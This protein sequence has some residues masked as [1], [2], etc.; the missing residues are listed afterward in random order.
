[1]TTPGDGNNEIEV[2]VH[3]VV[4]GNAEEIA[5]GLG[6]QAGAGW[7][8]GVESA[9]RPVLKGINT[10]EAEQQLQASLERMERR[11]RQAAQDMNVPLNPGSNGAVGL[12]GHDLEA[13]LHRY[14]RQMESYGGTVKPTFVGGFTEAL[15]RDT[16][17]LAQGYDELAE[18]NKR[19]KQIPWAFNEEG[20]KFLASAGRPT[21][22]SDRSGAF[23]ESAF[24]TP[25]R[26]G[27]SG[28][29]AERGDVDRILNDAN[30]RLL[31]GEA[32]ATILNDHVKQLAERPNSLFTQYGLGDPTT[33]Y[34]TAGGRT[35]SGQE[36]GGIVGESVRD[37]G[38]E[39]RGLS[40]ALV[41][42]KE[43]GVQAPEVIT[44]LEG[45]LHG[46]VEAGEQATRAVALQAQEE[47][48]LAGEANL[49]SRLGLAGPPNE[50]REGVQRRLD[51]AFNKPL[52]EGLPP[53][54]HGTL[55]AGEYQQEQRRNFDLLA[56][57]AEQERL[58]SIPPPYVPQPVPRFVRSAEEE[59]ALQARNEAESAARR[60]RNEENLARI[61]PAALESKQAREVF[62]E[63]QKNLGSG[64][65]GG[66]GGGPR[67]AVA[68]FPDD[69]PARRAI[70]AKLQQLT[71]LTDA[72]ILNGRLT[73]TDK[74]D[75]QR[76]GSF[77]DGN[78]AARGPNGEIFTASTN[79]GGSPLKQI[80]DTDAYAR[81]QSDLAATT[82]Q[83]AESLELETA[84]LERDG[85]ALKR[86]AQFSQDA[87]IAKLNFIASN[88]R[89]ADE[90]AKEIQDP[91]KLASALQRQARDTKAYEAE[92]R[93]PE[94]QRGFV[95]SFFHAATGGD[96]KDDGDNAHRRLSGDNGE[97][98][99]AIA[100]YQA[101][102]AVIFGLSQA[103]H[104]VLSE[105]EAVQLAM[106]E[107]GEAT[108][109][110]GD[111]ADKLASSLAQ[112]GSRAGLGVA[113]SIEAGTRGAFAF[114]DETRGPNGE[115]DSA[116][117]A[118][119]ATA[120][121]QTASIAA[122]ITQ[123][124]DAGVVQGQLIAT[125]RSFNLEAG[126]Q[127]RV[128]DAAANA[129]RHYGASTADILQGLPGVAGIAHQAG[130]SVEETANIISV[131][132]VRTAQTG[133]AVS[134][135]IGRV[136]ENINSKPSTKTLLDTFGVDTGGT[137]G[138]SLESLAHK[139]KD[140]TTAQQ[141]QIIA[142]LGGVRAAKDLIPVLQEGDNIL[143]A[144]E[145]SYK[146]GGYAQEL[147]YKQLNTIGG[148]LKLISGDLGIIGHDLASSGLFTVFGAALATIDP[149]LQGLDD[150][151]KI[152]GGLN[153]ATHG[154]LIPLLEVAAV[155][156]IISKEMT[157]NAALAAESAAAAT[158]EAGARTEEAVVT[159]GGPLGFFQRRAVGRGAALGAE[160]ARLTEAEIAASEAGIAGTAA[161]TAARAGAGAA[162]IPGL[163]GEVGGTA[164]LAETTAARGGLALMGSAL[165]GPVGIIVGL[166]AMT[167]AVGAITSKIREEHEAR[168]AADDANRELRTAGA[169][170]NN[171]RSAAAALSAAAVKQ[172]HANSGVTGFLVRSATDIAR[173][174]LLREQAKFAQE[175]ARQIEQEQRAATTAGAGEFFTH[176]G[177]VAKDFANGL[178][179]MTEAG[180]PAVRQLA[181]IT[182]ALNGLTPG[183]GKAA[184][185]G[186]SRGAAS[187]AGLVSNITS[188]VPKIEGFGGFAG[189]EVTPDIVKLG[190]EGTL[191]E[192]HVKV[193]DPITPQIR[194][195]IAQNL[196]ALYGLGD[197]AKRDHP[198]QFA[199]IQ[200]ELTQAVELSAGTNDPNRFKGLSQSEFNSAVLGDPSKHA[201]GLLAA[202]STQG[203]SGNALELDG[204]KL[205]PLAGQVNA[206]KA[207]VAQGTAA[208][209]VIPREVIDGLNQAKADLV[210]GQ[211]ASIEQIRKHELTGAS[212]AE[213]A[214][215]VNARRVTQEV[216]A[217]LD[218]NDTQ[219][220]INILDSADQ[221]TIDL[222]RHV[223]RAALAIAQKAHDLYL[224]QLAEF[225]AIPAAIR[226]HDPEL[227]GGGGG[228]PSDTSGYGK[229]KGDL[230]TFE[231]GAGRATA[232]D[233]P[234]V[235]PIA[236]GLAQINARADSRDAVQSA[237]TAV[238]AAQY[239]LDHA[240][241]VAAKSSAQKAL[242]DANH[243]YTA[244]VASNTQAIRTAGTDPSNAL[245]Q[246]QTAVANAQT[247]LN[248]TE[249]GTTAYYQ[250][251]ATLH[252]AQHSLGQAAHAH[253][254]AAAAGSARQGDPLSAA[255]VA[256]HAA[257][258]ALQA[259][260]HGSDAWYQ[261]LASFHAAQYAYGQAILARQHELRLN[262]IDTTNPVAVARE[263]LLTAQRTL[264]RDLHNGTG[265]IAADRN[266]VKDA[267][268][269]A[270]A[271]AFSQRLHDQ[272]Y[273]H[274]AGRESDQAYL[275]Y[276]NS[277]HDRLTR[278][279]HR[280]R[281]QTE[282]LQ[283]IDSA[284]KAA[285]VAA[286]GQFNLGDIK[287]PTP[288]EARR[289]IQASGQG[290]SYQSTN[291]TNVN[292]N[293]FSF[294][295]LSRQ[296]VEQVLRDVLGPA[297]TQRSAT[298]ARK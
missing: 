120:S 78:Y 152:V 222:V 179:A 175:Q 24:P 262:A 180:V 224:A 288:Y 106:V 195:K 215:Q 68:G 181:L 292:N 240:K 193:G 110:A 227:R 31:A 264:A 14:E 271:A 59:A 6:E 257:D 168:K 239:T 35:I 30:R 185:D 111:K 249:K 226:A 298:A 39:M 105:E 5:R 37:A 206:L 27:Y 136:L 158:V 194:A 154:W 82:R 272:Q 190:V 108:G 210:S 162:S 207:L 61:N 191:D 64:G 160:G 186:I 25:P 88:R 13:E 203:K 199:K 169:D 117:A 263:N 267:Q 96:K 225:N 163:A 141:D 255:T 151:L 213:Q 269:A 170:P 285:A 183:K 123:A 164:V 16:K 28:A 284:I 277:E 97:F 128:L 217:A 174:D 138:Q 232:T 286:Q 287:I 270:E 243:A 127:A 74:V 44:R 146:Q 252:S 122:F 62:E 12:F 116:K 40:D 43:V 95:G 45:A 11:V 208:G 49:H 10:Q 86:D 121:V 178:T 58:A 113:A 157:K 115:I 279:T 205:G 291:T 189:G 244:A 50:D 91:A 256:L 101:A 72:Q 8:Q 63:L 142:S 139:W 201:T 80:T 297:A 235:D 19:G 135:A 69:D 281:Q 276:L 137:A 153:N 17:L 218:Q 81:A 167:A 9:P 150:V 93:G 1:M 36:I 246:A 47:Q 57:Q 103:F 192:A 159:R 278:I 197:Q 60:Q 87:S 173:P 211:V 23:Q 3:P 247:A 55:T 166:I 223:L 188:A 132:A 119:V 219:A 18:V 34:P 4:E 26:G 216:R 237:R 149:F 109:L 295:G 107:F 20:R 273:A 118:S 145:Q 104:S 296:E 261:A 212:T 15:K 230:A 200:A 260:T 147:Y 171:Y 254:A 293:Q 241:G 231:A 126:D 289:Y 234:K 52:P 268:N 238:E 99:G 233:A 229:A 46:L 84:A 48:R 294:A 112:L 76:A 70:E 75:L 236:D 198:A 83:V 114:G 85:I 143:K 209:L 165:L 7:A 258:V 187:V 176:S 202:V 204:G 94:Q 266:A 280:T 172:E 2:A 155:L 283:Q 134:T 248:A 32:E 42:L 21:S 100:R 92:L 182:E 56:R 265:D 140:L 79:E 274:D 156:S 38:S 196:L 102:Y 131:A 133:T 65:A 33:Q 144:T 125:T 130:L 89:V 242:N 67:T 214:A 228:A 129:A 220:I 275:S 221:A 73:G 282:E 124:K 253:A 259:E 22:E 29:G 290:Q 77:L 148:A 54:Y 161:G 66:G 177:S 251:L 245:A 53:A 250:A 41:L 71:Q 51:A 90:Q 184:A 98:L